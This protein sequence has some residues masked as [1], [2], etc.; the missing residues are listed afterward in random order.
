MYETDSLQDTIIA[1]ASGR[2]GAVTLIRLSGKELKPLL[3]KHFRS[4]KPLCHAHALYGHMVDGEELIDEVVLTYYQAPHSYTGEDTAEIGC[5]AS[6]YIVERILN[7]FIQSG[8][9]MANPGEF[10][11]RSYLNGKRDLAEAEAVADLIHA[12]GEA[13]HRLAMAQLR[14]DYSQ[15][16]SDVRRRFI[17]FAS[18][19][20]LELDFSE[21]D[22]AFA[23]RDRLIAL[24]QE[25]RTQIRALI[26]SY[27]TG[28]KIRNGIATVICG[29]PNAGKSALLNALLRENRAIVS[30]IEGTTRDTVSE[31]IFIGGYPFR[32]IDTAGL[33]HTDN[34][35]EQLGVARS[36]EALSEA[37]IALLLIDA[38]RCAGEQDLAQQLKIAD[39]IKA[40]ALCVLNKIDLLDERSQTELSE[41]ITVRMP[42]YPLLLVSAKE[43]TGLKALEEAMV[44]LSATNSAEQASVI[45]TNL[46]H[47]ELL[48]K[49]DK[50]LDAVLNGLKRN[51]DS[52]LI[53]L[54]LRT[55]IDA[56]GEITGETIR[57]NDLLGHIFANFCIGK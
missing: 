43:R 31:T 36:R 15:T 18:L 3:R 1:P 45:V 6:P 44:R 42:K 26:D 39:E 54:E 38:T 57:D 55:A 47:L 49:A 48:E 24:A 5:H 32:I 51:T 50:G 14:G 9:R 8:A 10:T 23:D 34:P 33:R 17:E 21:E 13:Q 28:R 12:E 19:I 35:I 40:P 30:D 22:V 27:Q 29:I 56:I 37:D 7:C 4:A 46:R 20:E 2:G 53:A 52:A 16:L 11:L 41:R 25:V